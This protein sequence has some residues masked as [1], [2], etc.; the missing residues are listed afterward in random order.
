LI[1]ASPSMSLPAIKPAS[2]PRGIMKKGSS[3]KKQ[4]LPAV[5][6]AA[7]DGD[8]RG[9][10]V[11]GHATPS[12]RATEAGVDELRYTV[13]WQQSQVGGEGPINDDATST[14]MTS[15]VTTTIAARHQQSTTRKRP[16]FVSPSTLR[17]HRSPASLKKQTPTGQTKQHRH[18]RRSPR[19]RY[20]PR[21]CSRPRSRSRRKLTR[22]RP[23]C[24]TILK[25]PSHRCWM[26]LNAL[27]RQ[28]AF[29][30]ES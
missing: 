11:R 24:H 6:G 27:F 29:Y 3:A 19:S 21:S 5:S 10:A 1:A 23:H 17:K 13:R 12:A 4:Q 9:L 16:A 18:A 7:L 2:K 28:C 22:R 8:D 14:M 30:I 15:P 25:F 26:K 20:R